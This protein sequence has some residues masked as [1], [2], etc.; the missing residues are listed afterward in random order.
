LTAAR[1]CARVVGDLDRY[2]SCGSP[3]FMGVP[4]LFS[5]VAAD[6]NGSQNFPFSV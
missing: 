3:P 1:R 2:E 4:Q 6:R 5:R